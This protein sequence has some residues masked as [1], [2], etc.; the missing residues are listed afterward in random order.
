MQLPNH[1]QA[2]LLSIFCLLQC[3]KP[4]TNSEN[5]DMPA[6]L[7]VHDR[8]FFLGNSLTS[9]YGLLPGQA[10]PDLIQK[11][12]QSLLYKTQVI[13]AGHS[14]DTSAEALHR[15]KLY[16]LESIRPRCF[17]IELGSNDIFQEVPLINLRNNI[18]NIIKFT[19]TQSPGSRIYLYEMSMLPGMDNH[20]ADA[21]LKLF[22][23]ISQTQQ[24]NLIPFPLAGVAGNPE[25]NQADNLHPNAEG[26]RLMAENI[27]RSLQACLDPDIKK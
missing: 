6:D 12:L 23:I 9:G 5:K 13:N 11:R 18:V 17:L 26:T 16:N 4:G 15:L 1:L 20:Q 24:V 2:L 8:I 3:C 25:L 19:R 21:Y 14:G 27:W 22:S 7:T 10:V